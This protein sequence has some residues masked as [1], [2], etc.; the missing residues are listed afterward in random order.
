ML[1]SSPSSRR[2]EEAA[3]RDL[4]PFKVLAP[5]TLL[6]LAQDLPLK[7]KRAQDLKAMGE[8][9]G[10]RHGRGVLAAL[11]IAAE[12]IDAGE[13]PPDKLATNHTKDE[14]Q[15]MRE[16]RKVEERFKEWRRKEA[17]R[18]KVPNLIV[19]PNPAMQWLI[20]ER[21][22]SIEAIS[23]CADIGG[24]RLARYGKDLLR[25]LGN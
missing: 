7:A 15:R 19:L 14:L 6:A 2:E 10:R 25:L 3:Q 16:D 21:P 24:K 4:P 23:A 5:R 13:I 22:R 9:D 11:R 18:R 12:R 20:A 1:S 17:T 8:R